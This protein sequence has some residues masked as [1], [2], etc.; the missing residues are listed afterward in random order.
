MDVGQ[1]IA[2]KIN[3]VLDTIQDSLTD[4][5]RIA[6]YQSL[7]IISNRLEGVAASCEIE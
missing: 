5:E 7:T 3:L 2:E 4:E 1:K 6:F